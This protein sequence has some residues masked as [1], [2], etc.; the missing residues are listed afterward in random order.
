MS[1]LDKVLDALMKD[2]KELIIQEA[3]SED[4]DEFLALFREN[5]KKKIIE[6]IKEEYK[7]IL[8]QEAD[9]EIK[10]EVNRQKIEDLK[11]LMWSGFLLAFIVG[12]A[13]NQATDIIGYYKGTVT[14]DKIWPTIIITAVLC[15]ICLIAYLYS[16]WKNAVTLF[17]D[18]KT[19]K[20]K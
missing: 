4:R 14:A 9:I 20:P 12:L 16:F 6:E 17:D 10:K 11:S 19:E 13:V 8:I 2:K 3:P 5:K 1:E 15:M 7:Q 18:L